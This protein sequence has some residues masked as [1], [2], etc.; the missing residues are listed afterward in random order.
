MNFLSRHG[1]AE[2]QVLEFQVFRD[3]RLVDSFR[4]VPVN[5]ETQMRQ[6]RSA[7]KE[8]A[9][10]LPLVESTNRDHI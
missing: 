9:I 1:A 8:Q 6:E 3:P 2:L 4:S 10:V 7:A 5:G